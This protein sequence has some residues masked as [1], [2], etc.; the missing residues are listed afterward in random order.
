MWLYWPR[1]SWLKMF[2]PCWNDSLCIENITAF[3]VTTSHYHGKFKKSRRLAAAMCLHKQTRFQFL[4]DSSRVS[5]VALCG[6]SKNALILGHRVCTK[7]W[8]DVDIIVVPDKP[9]HESL[10]NALVSC[11]WRHPWWRPCLRQNVCWRI[12]RRDTEQTLTSLGRAG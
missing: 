3:N 6:Q 8:T 4:F 9:F 12:A 5:F 2:H 11:A 7:E 10:D 1:R